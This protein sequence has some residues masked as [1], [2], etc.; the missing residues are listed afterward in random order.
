MTTPRPIK[1]TMFLKTIKTQV[2]SYK[3]NNT[4]TNQ[5]NDVFKN[6]QNSSCFS[7]V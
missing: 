7:Q 6:N 4:Q 3:Y 1:W 5:V 2:V